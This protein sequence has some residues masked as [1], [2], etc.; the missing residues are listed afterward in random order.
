MDDL[1][2]QWLCTEAG[3]AQQV[4][5]GVW[6]EVNVGLGSFSSN[7]WHDAQAM[8]AVEV[9]CCGGECNIVPGVGVTW[10]FDP[11][12]CWFYDQRSSS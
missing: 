2:R 7:G 1:G 5:A 8:A 12:S 4:E 6:R 3:G 11:L 9:L 10:S